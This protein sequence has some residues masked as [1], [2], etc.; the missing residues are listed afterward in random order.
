VILLANPTDGSLWMF[1]A[2][3]QG[4]G[5]DI[6]NPPNGSWW[7]VQPQPRDAARVPRIRQQYHKLPRS[8][9]DMRGLGAEEHACN[10][11]EGKSEVY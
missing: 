3:L 7:I 1:Q 6:S 4:H 5:P 9:F 11:S 8:K 2:C 10:K